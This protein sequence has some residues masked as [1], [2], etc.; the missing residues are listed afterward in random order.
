[1]GLGVAE[2]AAQDRPQGLLKVVGEDL[3][4]ELPADDQLPVEGEEALGGLVPG[5]DE[6][7]RVE[8]G[9]AVGRALDQRRGRAREDVPRRAFGPAFTGEPE[10]AAGSFRLSFSQS[11]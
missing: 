10:Q 2:L 9:D 5:D 11:Q 1:M 7:L 6:A 4:G 8:Y 3:G